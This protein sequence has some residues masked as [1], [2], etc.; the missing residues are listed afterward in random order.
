MWVR[1]YLIRYCSLCES[2]VVLL[3][4]RPPE[5]NRGAALFPFEAFVES[6]S[7]FWFRM[8]SNPTSPILL[9]FR[10][11]AC[12][13]VI[14]LVQHCKVSLR[15]LSCFVSSDMLANIDGLWCRSFSIHTSFSCNFESSL[16]WNHRDWKVALTLHVLSTTCVW[17]PVIL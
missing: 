6:R 12:D 1:S 8:E 3:H 13:T 11:S 10:W 5:G 9:M 4:S 15:V 7:L 2:V 16:Y 17:I 14:S